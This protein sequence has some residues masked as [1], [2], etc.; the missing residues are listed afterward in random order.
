MSFDPA[1]GER[2]QLAFA[3]QLSLTFPLVPDVGKNLSMLYESAFSPDQR[4]PGRMTVLID[5]D[6]I[7]RFVDRA[8]QVRTHGPDMLLKM[9]ELG[10][11]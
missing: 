1:E 6:G 10:M 4:A 9:R 2:G 8:V 11:K 7:V 3:R 5:R